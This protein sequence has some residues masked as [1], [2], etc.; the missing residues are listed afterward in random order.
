VPDE[1]TAG[2][3]LAPPHYPNNVMFHA[4]I[5]WKRGGNSYTMYDQRISTKYLK[6]AIDYYNQ[7][8]QWWNLHQSYDSTSAL[9]ADTDDKSSKLVILN[10]PGQMINDTR[11]FQNIGRLT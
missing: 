6:K 8:N 4:M 3:E 1:T 11:M 7:K 2:F 10:E 9:F 5:S